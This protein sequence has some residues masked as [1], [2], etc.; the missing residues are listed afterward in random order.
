MEPIT[1]KKPLEHKQSLS[2]KVLGFMGSLGKKEAGKMLSNTVR[3]E[4]IIQKA[5]PQITSGNAS[6]TNHAEPIVSQTV[7]NNDNN[8]VSVSVGTEKIVGTMSE[9]AVDITTNPQPENTT[10]NND[11]HSVNMEESAELIQAETNN[12]PIQAVPVTE[13]TNN[14]K[15]AEKPQVASSWKK[16]ETWAILQRL[17]EKHRRLVV[18]LV[19][20]IL[21]LLFFLSFKSDPATVDSYQPDA[22]NNLPIEFQPLDQSAVVVKETPAPAPQSAENN[23]TVEINGVSV[24]T[25][26]PQSESSAVQQLSNA[27]TAPASLNTKP[28]PTLS[29][30]EPEVVPQQHPSMTPAPQVEKPN[31]DKP[32]IVEN[33]KPVT[34]PTEKPKAT[35][36]ET[37][38]TPQGSTI[39]TP[40]APIV[41]AKSAKRPT[42]TTSSGS[43]KTL[44]IEKGKTLFQVFRDNGLDIRDA[45]AM[46]KASGVGNALS[47]FKPGDKIQVSTSGG[48]VTELRLPSGSRFVRQSDGTYNYK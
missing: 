17:P 33:N 28:T 30:P 20:A 1:P 11:N 16:P 6:V 27:M 23:T 32:R 40:K 14:E 9:N 31:T 24:N 4:P 22:A 35:I 39:K 8:A 18:A 45:N 29:A 43:R 26:N 34:K 36:A 15:T 12:E 21:V 19:G 41:E 44:T 3:Q 38:Q 48:H 37:K 25:M 13:K 46:T 47:N 2:D 42:T 10:M 7:E 5:E